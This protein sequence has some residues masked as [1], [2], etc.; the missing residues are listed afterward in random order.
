MKITITNLLLSC[1]YQPSSFQCH[2]VEEISLLWAS[3]DQIDLVHTWSACAVNGRCRQKLLVRAKCMHCTWALQAQHNGQ[4]Y[5]FSSSFLR[6]PYFIINDPVSFQNRSVLGHYFVQ[7]ASIFQCWVIIRSEFSLLLSYCIPSHC[8]MLYSIDSG[9]S[10][11]E[12]IIN[13][14]QF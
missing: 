12:N 2:K 4:Y 5:S 13:S 3:G 8:Q 11:G 6:I 1:F 9:N 10:A 14:L 7:K